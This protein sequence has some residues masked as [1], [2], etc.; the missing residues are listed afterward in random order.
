[1][2]SPTESL[3]A[4]PNDAIAQPSQAEIAEALFQAERRR[5]LGG[6][7]AAA[8][9][10]VSPWST[11]LD[12]YLLKR[13]EMPATGREAD[14]MRAKILKR[15]KR[16]E[17]IVREM[18][19]EEWGLKITKFS[20][21]ANPNRYKD[22]E[23]DFLA[24]EIDFEWEVTPEIA[25]TLNLSKDLIG[26]VQNGEIKT[27]HPFA[28]AKF[29]EEESDE[30]PI[31]YAAQAMHGLMVTKRKV[32]LF[33]VLVGSDNLLR[34][35]VQRDDETIAAMRDKEVTFWRDHVLAGVPPPAV[36]LSDIYHLFRRDVGFTIQATEAMAAMV[37]DLKDA[38]QAVK[39]AE[40]SIDD[41]QFRIGVAMLGEEAV[42]RDENGKT[43]P[44]RDAPPGKH[45][46]KV[47]AK[48]LLTV[49]FNQQQRID[50]DALRSRHPD[51]V[52]ECTKALTFWSF[53]LS[54][55][56]Q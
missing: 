33:A 31:E 29:G 13:G 56:K 3:I 7:D 2:N 25:E 37:N 55:K 54:R 12:V 11:P 48:E 28:A 45:I 51:V 39:N 53:N 38:K 5:Y 32:C 36:N 52:A 9:F 46:L 10:G 49:R 14:P 17:P 41:L 44:G 16:L 34:Y 30:V 35:V 47:G 4:M 22:P 42:I 24:A 26:T 27:T 8:V 1:M 20:T 18:A 23:H 15:G 21:E 19:Q 40:V 50:N 43:V 6:S